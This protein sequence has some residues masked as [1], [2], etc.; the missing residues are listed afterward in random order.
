M[1]TTLLLIVALIAGG[2]GGETARQKVLRPAIV[3]SWYS[4]RTD[5][6][7]PNVMDSAVKTCDCPMLIVA[8]SMTSVTPTGD[9]FEV[10]EKQE[11]VN[12]LNSAIPLYCK[13]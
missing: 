10:I 11:T 4:I 13:E 6:A 9:E 12:L 2:C 8:W 3:E 7:D 1:R 5:A